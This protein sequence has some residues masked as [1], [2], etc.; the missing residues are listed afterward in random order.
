MKSLLK[1]VNILNEI[2]R[3]NLSILISGM[4]GTG[5]TTA[6]KEITKTL[7]YGR[8]IM[9]AAS[10]IEYSSWNEEQTF[11]KVYNVDL[12]A[13]DRPKYGITAYATKLKLDAV[14]LD[15]V[16]DGTFEPYILSRCGI[17]VIYVRHGRSADEGNEKVEEDDSWAAG[18]PLENPFDITVMCSING[19]TG[20][21]EYEVFHFLESTKR[22]VKI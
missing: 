19:D 15:E 4:T 9:V 11:H 14:L 22:A 21:R 1:K 3:G 5:K 12:S 10:P 20:E 16:Y 17:P 8:R 13:K 2:T 7:Y 18:V 6:A